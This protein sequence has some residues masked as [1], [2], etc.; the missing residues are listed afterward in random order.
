MKNFKKLSLQCTKSV[1][2]FPVKII[3]KNEY[4]KFVFA[5]Y[6]AGQGTIKNAQKEAKAMNRNPTA[7]DELIKGGDQSPLYKA[8]ALQ[9]A[10]YPTKKDILD[11]YDETT[12]YVEKIFRRLAP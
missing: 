1:D 6:N 3:N 10:K 7:W 8:I 2:N 11:K 9:K 5:S 12:R 4:K